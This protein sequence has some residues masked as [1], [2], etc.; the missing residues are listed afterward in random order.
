MFTAV[1]FACHIIFPD[2]C[3]HVIDVRGPY[4]T[5]PACIVRVLEMQEDTKEMFKNHKVPFVLIAW[6]CDSENTV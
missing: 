3:V 2:Q 6:K 4:P 1:L 5:R